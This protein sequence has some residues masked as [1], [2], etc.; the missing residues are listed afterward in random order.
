[1]PQPM[2]QA[3]DSLI[4]SHEADWA[5]ECLYRQLGSLPENN[6]VAALMGSTRLVDWAPPFAGQ[7]YVGGPVEMGPPGRSYYTSFSG[8]W[9]FTGPW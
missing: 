2:S 7:G 1:M 9:A 6:L 8:A 5:L 3:L 4:S